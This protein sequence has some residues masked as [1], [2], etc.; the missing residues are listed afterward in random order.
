MHVEG[1]TSLRPHPH[2][3]VLVL[4]HMIP[5]FALRLMATHLRLISFLT[6]TTMGRDLPRISSISIYG[7]R[8][9]Y[10]RIFITLAPE[11]LG[12]AMSVFLY[13]VHVCVYR[14]KWY[15]RCLIH[16]LIIWARSCG[17]S[18]TPGRKLCNRCNMVKS[19]GMRRTVTRAKEKVKG[20]G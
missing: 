7:C 19:T 6:A 20:Q 11:P 2:R 9:P 8:V 3:S 1:L 18:G 12:K 10:R 5:Q 15:T 16:G 4:H 14:R 17:T 13:C